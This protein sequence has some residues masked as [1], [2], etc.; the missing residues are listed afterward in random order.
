MASFHP[1]YAKARWPDTVRVLGVRLVPLTIDHAIL[2]WRINS[3]FV[4]GGPIS[5]AQLV[6][7][8]YVL[9]RPCDRAAKGLQGRCAGWMLKLWGWQLT[10]LCA[11]VRQALAICTVGNYIE[12]A[13][14]G[15]T[16]WEGEGG[17]KSCSS[18]FLQVLKCRLQSSLGCTN[19]NAFAYPVQA[20]IWDLACHAEDSG[21]ADVVNAEDAE[22]IERLGRN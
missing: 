9:S 19:E 8:V 21:R 22:A 14:Q 15:P 18:P 11:D 7:A 2:L 10:L 4:A 20:A 6:T 16:L 3:P 13:F 17:A 1:E 5:L 12:Q